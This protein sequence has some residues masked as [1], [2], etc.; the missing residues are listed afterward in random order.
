MHLPKR[1]PHRLTAAENLYKLE[2]AVRY[3]LKFFGNR[4]DEKLKNRITP[5]GLKRDIS[6]T[7]KRVRECD[8]T[9]TFAKALLCTCTALSLL[10][11][12]AR[13]VLGLIRTMRDPS[14]LYRQLQLCSFFD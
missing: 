14:C 6:N 13:P 3:D 11:W 9:V 8:C 10:N 5:A 7:R 12:G 4:L 1:A 2:R